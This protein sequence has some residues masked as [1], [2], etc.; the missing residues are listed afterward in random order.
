LNCK[1]GYTSNPNDPLRDDCI[2]CLN[3]ECL[4]PEV[5]PYNSDLGEWY[6]YLIDECQSTLQQKQTEAHISIVEGYHIVGKLIADNQDQFDR[7]NYGDKVIDTVASSLGK[8]SRTIR[9]AVALARA[10]P[11]FNSIPLGNNM[12]WTKAIKLIKNGS[13]E[14]KQEHVCTDYETVERCK[15]CHKIKKDAL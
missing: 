8:K 2:S 1:Q 5:K 14:E 15:E 7:C 12:S 4:I 11:D 13:K 10:Y 6:N 3:K 9:Y